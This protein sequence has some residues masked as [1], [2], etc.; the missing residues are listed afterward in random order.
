MISFLKTARSRSAAVAA[1]AGLVLLT[2]TGCAGWMDAR[3]RR[4]EGWREADVVQIDRG[5]VIK[6]ELARDCRRQMNKELADNTVF[7]VYRFRGA[8]RYQ[9]MIAP[10]GENFPFKVGDRVSVNI[11][12]CE[13]T[14]KRL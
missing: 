8:D 10:R 1:G 4:A 12:S 13:A 14:P 11:D 9:H 5:A 6:R 7:A 2:T 3:E